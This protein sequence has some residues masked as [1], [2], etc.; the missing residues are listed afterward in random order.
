MSVIGK[1][2]AKSLMTSA[3]TPSLVEQMRSR[4]QAIADDLLD[5]VVSHGEMVSTKTG[6][7]SSRRFWKANL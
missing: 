4:A 5:R 1:G 3:F 7:R 6:E 2:S